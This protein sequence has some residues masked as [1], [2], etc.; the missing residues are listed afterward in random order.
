MCDFFSS[1]TQGNGQMFYFNHNQKQTI[2]KEKHY[3]ED[4]HTS[5]RN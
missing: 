1:V 4:S 5:I 2:C 3:G